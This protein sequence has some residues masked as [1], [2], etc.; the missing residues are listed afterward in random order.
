MFLFAETSLTWNSFTLKCKNTKDL[1]T[2]LVERR[3]STDIDNY[4]PKKPTEMKPS[5]SHKEEPDVQ[6]RFK[7]STSKH[8]DN[9]SN[10]FNSPNQYHLSRPLWHY[11]YYFIILKVLSTNCFYQT[12]IGNVN[13]EI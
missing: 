1:L 12:V 5:T 2:S 6:V 11:Q 3:D 10:Y 8:S 13:L 7:I 9:N 4:L